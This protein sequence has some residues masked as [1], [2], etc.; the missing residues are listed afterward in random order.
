[1]IR[2]LVAR[3]LGKAARGLLLMVRDYRDV[4]REISA[5]QA[6]RARRR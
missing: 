5:H 6:K 4:C 3:Q 2:H 1:M